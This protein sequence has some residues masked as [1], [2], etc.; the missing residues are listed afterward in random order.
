VPKGSDGC[1][2]RCTFRGVDASRIYLR[3]E[4]GKLAKEGDA[5]AF[6]ER[7]GSTGLGSTVDD[8]NR[9]FATQSLVDAE[10]QALSETALVELVEAC[11][12]WRANG[13]A[14]RI[15]GRRSRIACAAVGDVYLGPA[16]GSLI[17]A[18]RENGRRLV[19]IARD[20]RVLDAVPYRDLE[21]GRIVAFDTLIAEALSSNAFRL[22]D[23][24]HRAIQLA[25]NGEPTVSLCVLV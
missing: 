7:A 3:A 24:M 22:I 18:F 12:R 21:P 20:P 1:R 6:L 4:L 9:R 25:R 17:P 13:V 10:V 23:G 11:S 19:D 2:R 8:L 16:E 15:R 5:A 14:E